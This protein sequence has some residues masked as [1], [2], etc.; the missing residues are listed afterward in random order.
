[1]GP[2]LHCTPAHMVFQMAERVCVC[3]QEDRERPNR[4]MEQRLA[5]YR[6]ECEARMQE[7]VQR[8]VHLKPF[9]LVE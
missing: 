2:Q 9:V 4:T 6:Q 3:M 7:E 1:M 5:A 8:Q